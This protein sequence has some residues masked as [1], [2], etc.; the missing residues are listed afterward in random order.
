M[1]ADRPGPV[2][3]LTEAETDALNECECGHYVNEHSSDGCLANTDN[4]DWRHVDGVCVCVASPHTIRVHAMEA[5]VRGRLAPVLAL[6]DEWERSGRALLKH[7]GGVG[8]LPFGD[9]VRRLREAAR[10]GDA[11]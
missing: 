9:A 6:A 7:G 1:S 2:T 4:P 5:V 10:G 3:F 11:G 8:S